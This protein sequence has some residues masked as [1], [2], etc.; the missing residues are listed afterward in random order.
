MEER[1]GLCAFGCY[2]E[3]EHRSPNPAA[4]ALQPVYD[5]QGR[6]LRRCRECGDLFYSS[7]MHAREHERLRQ[8]AP[9]RG[10]N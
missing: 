2:W 4:A 9:E 1:A 3:C 5:D 6:E 10:S 8:L 7:V